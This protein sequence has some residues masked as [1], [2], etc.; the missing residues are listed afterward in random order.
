MQVFQL[1]EGFGGRRCCAAAAAHELVSG[2]A[3]GG[4]LGLVREL[5]GLSGR[6]NFIAEQLVRGWAGLVYSKEVVQKYN[7]A[8]MWGFRGGAVQHPDAAPQAGE[9]MYT[10]AP[11]LARDT[12]GV[13]EPRFFVRRACNHCLKLM[14]SAETHKQ[15]ALPPLR[16]CFVSLQLDKRAYYPLTTE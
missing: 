14:L 9:C 3:G 15:P 6:N 1:P 12:A 7:H 13:N 16:V 10:S 5:C 2:G 4:L 8:G 11:E